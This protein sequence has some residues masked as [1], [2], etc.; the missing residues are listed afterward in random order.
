MYPRV[1]LRISMFHSRDG[2]LCEVVY[3]LNTCTYIHTLISIE[4][5][6]IHKYQHENDQRKVKDRQIKLENIP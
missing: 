4:L 3:N 2:D 6:Q 1:W 5:A